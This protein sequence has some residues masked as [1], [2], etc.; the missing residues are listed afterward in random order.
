MLGALPLELLSCDVTLV[1]WFYAPPGR[2]GHFKKSRF[3][4][5]T[6]YPLGPLVR[7]PTE[8]IRRVFFF[9]VG[10]PLPGMIRGKNVSY[11]NSH[12]THNAPGGWETTERT[13]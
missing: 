10:W 4:R 1:T 12:S 5:T 9:V 6:K 2:G 8:K 7:P 13:L 11:A 3:W